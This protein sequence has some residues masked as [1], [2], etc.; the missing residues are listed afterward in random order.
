MTRPYALEHRNQIAALVA[1]YKRK[2]EMVL[3]RDENGKLWRV[4]S[5]RKE[6][7]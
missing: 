4:R 6:L 2:H 5:V 7:A 1:D 3:D